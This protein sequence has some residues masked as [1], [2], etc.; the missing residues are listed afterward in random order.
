MLNFVP[1]AVMLVS[2]FFKGFFFIIY[3]LFKHLT[4]VRQA[5]M[6]LQVLTTSVSLPSSLKFW[7]SL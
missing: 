3:L 5:V 1:S 4:G 6:L 7:A 2:L